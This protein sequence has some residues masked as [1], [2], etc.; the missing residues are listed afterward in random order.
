M[1]MN[2]LQAWGAAKKR[3]EAAPQA[4]NLSLIHI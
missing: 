4:C 1:A 2:L 3:L